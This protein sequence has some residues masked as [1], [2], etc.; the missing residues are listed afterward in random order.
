MQHSPSV[1]PILHH[2]PLVSL[3][4]RLRGRAGISAQH[5]RLDAALMDPERL[6]FNERF[7][8]VVHTGPTAV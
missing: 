2:P 4:Q 3:L 5:R 1:D 7:I 6:F 8:H